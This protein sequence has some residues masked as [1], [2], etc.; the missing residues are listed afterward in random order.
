M[1]QRKSTSNSCAENG[2]VF[3]HIFKLQRAFRRVT[4]KMTC[5]LLDFFLSSLN[6]R[7]SIFAC[8][9]FSS[10]KDKSNWFYNMPSAVWPARAYFFYYCICYSRKKVP[11]SR[12]SR[13]IL[14]LRAIVSK[15]FF[16]HTPL[17]VTF[18]ACTLIYVYLFIIY[19][20]I[21]ITEV[22]ILSSCNPVDRLTHSQ[23]LEVP[24]SRD[25]WLKAASMSS[26]R[27]PVLH[28]NVSFNWK[29]FRNDSVS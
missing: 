23:G 22:L 17:S 29:M 13:E 25:H 27:K 28:K 3:P 21:Y 6:A 14:R 20:H 2:K 26:G 10:Q 8:V 15:L 19:I 7:Y 1:P 16:D 24:H 9:C 12:N 4:V 11:V 5:C 18:W